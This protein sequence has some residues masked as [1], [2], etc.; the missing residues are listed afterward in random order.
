MMTQDEYIKQF[1]EDDAVGWDCIDNKLKEIYGDQ[2]PRH[3]GTLIKYRFGGRDPLDGISI[4]DQNEPVFHRHIVSYG[5]SELYYN[6]EQAG[7]KF[8]KWGFEFTFRVVPYLEDEEYNDAEHEPMWAAYI[9]Q[10]LARIVFE[11]NKPFKPYFFFE[12]GAINDE[13][14][15]SGVAFVIDPVLGKIDTPHGEVIFLQMVG[16]TQK[17]LDWLWEDPNSNRCEE[18]IN[19]MRVDNLMLITDLNRTKEYV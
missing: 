12:G 14:K 10:H 13:T 1:N 4:Y 7:E 6:P 2:E 3:Y 9:M 11:D 15:I 17:E 18:L 8:S 19:K 16:L 5:M